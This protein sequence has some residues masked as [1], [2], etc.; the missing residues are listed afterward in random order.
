M[1]DRDLEELS[2]KM[3]IELHVGWATTWAIAWVGH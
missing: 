3:K 1:R 2:W